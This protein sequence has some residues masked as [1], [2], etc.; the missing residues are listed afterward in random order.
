MII[1]GKK[2]SLE[3]MF[4]GNTAEEQ[5]KIASTLHEAFKGLSDY[6][7]NAVIIMT[8]DDFAACRC[9]GI[10]MP[11]GAVV[12]LSHVE[13]CLSS[14]PVNWMDQL[15]LLAKPLRESPRKRG[16]VC[17]ILQKDPEQLQAFSFEERG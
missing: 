12:I 16:I 13:R 6:K 14:S 9:R 1:Y 5:W 15:E 10:T 4:L 3:R 8:A 11:K 2:Y 7:N 17:R